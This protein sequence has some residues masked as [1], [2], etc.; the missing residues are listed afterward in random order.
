MFFCR[1]KCQGNRGHPGT[2]SANPQAT[3]G[4]PAGKARRVKPRCPLLV[5]RWHV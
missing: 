1:G 3:A 4:R 5:A 2:I